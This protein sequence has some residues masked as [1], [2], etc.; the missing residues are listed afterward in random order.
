MSQFLINTFIGF[1]MLAAFT[2]ISGCNM[3]LFENTDIKDV[4]EK[5]SDGD[6]LILRDGGG[7]KHKVRLGCCRCCC[8]Y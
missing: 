4:V 5:I 2:V 6:T 1:S 7:E 3:Y 8:R